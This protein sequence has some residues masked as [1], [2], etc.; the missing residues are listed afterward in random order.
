M[1]T[2]V[3]RAGACGVLVVAAIAGCSS[4]KKKASPP[5]PPTTT[6]TTVAGSAATPGS[7]ASTDPVAIAVNTTLLT[8]AEV[9]RALS[10]PSTPTTETVSGSSTPQG[11]LN[12]TGLLS[13]LPGAA[14]YKPMFDSAGGSV[15]A[16]ATY[17]AGKMDIDL[18]AIKFSTPSGA[19]SFV[20]QVINLATVLARGQAT[21]H[22][23]LSIG[24]LPPADRVVVRVPPSALADADK[25]TVATSIVYSNGVLFLISLLGPVGTITDQQL[26][27]LA[28]AQ[29]AKWGTERP[30]LGIG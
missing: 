2:A 29:D 28:H 3:I 27:G 7:N 30:R 9:Q 4:T 26:I 16:N 17:H 12:E 22:P 24:V 13:V 6:L 23:E 15:G 1:A 18:A 25:E 20:Q 5:A 21:P 11:P 19:Q 14:V 10:L 8:P